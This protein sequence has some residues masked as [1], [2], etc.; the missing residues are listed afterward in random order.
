MEGRLPTAPLPTASGETR[1][2]SPSAPRPL[3]AGRSGPDYI[4]R[5]AARVGRPAPSRPWLALRSPLPAPTAPRPPGRPSP[6]GAS[7]GGVLK[8]V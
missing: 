4:S 7:L 8:R 3:C 2:V 5:G 6:P 1:G